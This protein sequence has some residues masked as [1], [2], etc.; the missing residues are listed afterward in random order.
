MWTNKNP[1]RIG[2]GLLGIQRSPA[3]PTVPDHHPAA[4]AEKPQLAD[5]ARKTAE[6]AAGPPAT[7]EPTTD[8]DPAPFS[9]LHQRAI[10]FPTVPTRI[11]LR[12]GP[13]LHHRGTAQP[14]RLT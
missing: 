8:P 7:S 10:A 13:G 5:Q 3:L 6:V 12:T 2:Q 11:S 4:E 14:A 9:Q 1:D